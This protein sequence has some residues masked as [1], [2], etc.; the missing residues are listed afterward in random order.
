MVEL[1]FSFSEIQ[2]ISTTHSFDDNVLCVICVVVVAPP[3]L[4][5]QQQA[6]STNVSP[7]PSLGSW[8]IATPPPNGLHEQQYRTDLFTP[9]GYNLAL[10]PIANTSH[11]IWPSLCCISPRDNLGSWVHTLQH[12]QVAAQGTSC[13]ASPPLYFI[14]K[15][16]KSPSPREWRGHHH[17][18][19]PSSLPGAHSAAPSNGQRLSPLIPGGGEHWL[20]GI[21]C[22][23]FQLFHICFLY[24]ACVCVLSSS[25]LADPL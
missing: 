6:L 14:S 22:S 21:H 7:H 11:R 23:H 13:P 3:P 20:L 8:P 17:T 24:V 16:L 4:L 2:P 5:S 9:E 18:S 19:Q 1:L 12:L 25:I 10:W 15:W